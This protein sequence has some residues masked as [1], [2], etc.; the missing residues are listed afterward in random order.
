[1]LL[2]EDV[3]ACNILLPL[4]CW[5]KHIIDVSGCRVNSDCLRWSSIETDKFLRLLRSI[6]LQVLT[7]L[8]QLPL[9]PP[10]CA[11]LTTPCVV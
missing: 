9:S 5:R 3:V 7:T 11:I 1:M 6:T 8:A 4:T 10:K 2:S